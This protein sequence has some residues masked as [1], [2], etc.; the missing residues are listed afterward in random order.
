[1]GNSTTGPSTTGAIPMKFAVTSASSVRGYSITP[2]STNP[3]EISAPATIHAL[4]IVPLL[5]S[6]DCEPELSKVI[7]SLLEEDEPKRATEE[8]Y[9][10]R[11]DNRQRPKLVRKFLRCNEPMS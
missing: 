1:M 4:M 11:V 3:A 9:K 10:S 2:R 6:I 7:S 5:R 8:T